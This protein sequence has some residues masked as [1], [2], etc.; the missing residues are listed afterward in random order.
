MKNTM[1]AAAASAALAFGASPAFAIT[2]AQAKAQCIV[3]EQADG[4]LGF[5]N[6]SEADEELR[7]EVR[8]INQ[9]R[10]AAYEQLAQRN[11]VTVDVAAALTA[12]RLMNQA[13]SGH[14]IREQGGSWRRK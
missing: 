14:C 9:Q 13:P 4:Y 8:S 5:A 12:E 3:G 6:A 7:R 2:V 1:I 10:R 11:G